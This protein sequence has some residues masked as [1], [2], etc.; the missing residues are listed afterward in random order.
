LTQH[1]PLSA[2][3]W[4]ITLSRCRGESSNVA[5]P[6]LSLALEAFSEKL[7]TE[8]KQKAEKRVCPPQPNQK[9]FSDCGKNLTVRHSLFSARLFSR[10][11]DL[12]I[13]RLADFSC[14]CPS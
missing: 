11:A 7:S 2:A 6:S 5:L 4:G 14:P 13:S 3:K 8:E 10:P 12:P 9:F 1:L